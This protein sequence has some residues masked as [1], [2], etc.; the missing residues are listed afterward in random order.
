MWWCGGDK[1]VDVVCG[2][3]L[4]IVHA[5]AWLAWRCV[6]AAGCIECIRGRLDGED[7]GVVGEEL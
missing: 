5:V 7:D 6:G 1:V 3:W 2:R 4:S